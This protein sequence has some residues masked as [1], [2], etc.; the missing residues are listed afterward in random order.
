MVSQ[1]YRLLVPSTLVL[2]A[3]FLLYLHA[4]ELEPG[5][6]R[7]DLV[8]VDATLIDGTGAPPYSATVIVRDGRI[9]AVE[10]DSEPAVLAGASVI[11]A[12]GKYLIPGLADMHVHLS[13]GL[14]QPRLRNETEI[15]LARN[16]YYGVTSILAIGASDAST[17]SILTHRARREAG[18]LQS[19]YIYGTGGHLTIKGTHPVYTAFPQRVQQVADELADATPMNDPIDLYSLGIGLS[20]VRTE[21]AARKAVQ[22]RAEG[23]MDAIKI[24][25]ESGPTPFGDDHPQMSVQMIRAIVDEAA[26]HDLR[27]FAHV[28]SLDELRATFDGGAAGTVHAVWNRPFPDADL[29]HRLAAKPFYVMPTTS[30]YRGTVSLHYVD[31]PI[32]LDDPFLRETV[33][34][35]EVAGLRDPE[36][37]ARFRSRWDRPLP[38][39][40][41][42]EES[43]RLHVADLLSNVGML[44]DHGVPVVLGTDT[45]NMFTF[46]GFSVHDELEHLVKA[47]LTPGEAL[48]AA[49]TNA[50][51]MLNAE[52][53]FGTIEPGK[54]ADLLILGAN[55]LSDIRNTRSLEFVIAE[56]RLVDRESLPV[57]SQ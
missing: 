28:T 10:T 3:L 53:E 20:I 49:T 26:R 57:N 38:S 4:S 40:D 36:F 9:F 14:P 50:A 35:K 51:E 48:A 13:R 21:E 37:I 24:T 18:E 46:Q 6:G 16:L 56:G 11:D 33:S 55:P 25:V 44:S 23:R 1:S 52:D 8:I 41:N 27:V 29:A 39:V 47:G 45:G 7:N 19:P 30:I 54:R 12:S 15:V 43:I 2:A 31:E 5:A 17:Q 22:E 32:D 42:R 34:D